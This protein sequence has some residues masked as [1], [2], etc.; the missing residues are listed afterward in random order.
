MVFMPVAESS[1]AWVRRIDLR[2][3]RAIDES[4]L[5]YITLALAM[6]IVLFFRNI[7]Q[8]LLH[9]LF[10]AGVA[11]FVIAAAFLVWARANYMPPS[12]KSLNAEKN[13][14]ADAIEIARKKYMHRELS[15]TGFN[16]ISKEKQVRLIE[17]EALIEQHYEKA[18]KKAVDRQLLAVQ[19]KKRHLLRALLGEKKRILKELDIAKDSYLKRKLD[20]RTYKAMAQKKQL[21]LIELEAEIKNL[22]REEA[23][24][25]VLANKK[26]GKEKK[27]NKKNA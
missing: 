10:F 16:K 5:F 22:F 24:S 18:S 9:G 14:L 21:G 15:E 11:L 4:P 8:L 13:R 1:M 25:R 23:K 27:N 3:R 26:L 20:A 7:V 2:I 12:L 6:L 19:A 17:V